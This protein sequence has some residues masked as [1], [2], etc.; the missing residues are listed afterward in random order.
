MIGAPEFRKNYKGF[1]YPYSSLGFSIFEFLELC[2]ALDVTG[3]PD[4][5]GEETP[6]DMAD[7]IDYALGTDE[8]NIWVKKRIQNGR[9]KPYRLTHLQYGN[10]EAINT[11][12]AERF[13]AVA[14][15]IY[16]KTS[17]VQLVVGDFAYNRAFDNPNDINDS[18]SPVV[19][20]LSGQKIILDHAAKTGREIWFDIH[21]WTEKIPHPREHFGG[22]DDFYRHLKTLCPDAKFKRVVFELNAAT[23]DLE[24]ALCNAYAINGLQRR[25]DKCVICCSANGLQVDTNN[26]NGW[27]QGLLFIYGY[28]VIMAS[29]ARVCNQNGAYRRLSYSL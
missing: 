1:W 17:A 28:G 8:N 27:N 3:I 26:D 25:S 22:M 16:A 13:N 15:A 11:H 7:F 19:K 9:A 24:R 29:S 21:F 12:Y 10:E 14:D 5:C 4:F 2:E 18:V 20:N 23:H 6:Q